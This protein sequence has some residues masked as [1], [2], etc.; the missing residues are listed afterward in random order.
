MVGRY[1]RQ[2]LCYCLADRTLE[3]ITEHLE[4]NQ[5]EDNKTNGVQTLD[6]TTRAIDGEKRKRA[7]G[8]LGGWLTAR[9]NDSW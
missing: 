1:R 6:L 8:A 2:Y 5:T 7:R 9:Q 4:N 3:L